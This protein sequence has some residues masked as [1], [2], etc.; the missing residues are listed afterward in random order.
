MPPRA[1]RQLCIFKSLCNRV[2]RNPLVCKLSTLMLS[3]LWIGLFNV[4]S[5]LPLRSHLVLQP[6]F[7]TFRSNQHIS[8]HYHDRNNIIKLS[9]LVG[10]A[11]YIG[12]RS[13]NFWRLYLRSLSLLCIS[14]PDGLRLNAL[15]T[16][17]M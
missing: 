2:R 15:I 10:R 4:S 7:L 9:L 13:R 11:N 6:R 3:F 12:I 14:A 16:T 1:Q 5:Q 17:S 8:R